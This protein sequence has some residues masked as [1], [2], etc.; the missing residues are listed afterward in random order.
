MPLLPPGSPSQDKAASG[1][2]ALGALFVCLRKVRPIVPVSFWLGE[3]FRR[4]TSRSSTVQQLF[5]QNL[6]DANCSLELSRL[7]LKDV[8]T[9][10]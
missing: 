6:Y 3:E 9:L 10:G 7:C 5:G 2:L 4:S 1:N 8:S